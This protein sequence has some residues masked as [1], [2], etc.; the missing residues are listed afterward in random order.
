DATQIGQ[1][2]KADAIIVGRVTQFETLYAGLYASFSVAFELKMIASK[3]SEVLWSVK[4]TETQRTG[5]V[6]LSPIG[7]IIAAASTAM[8][9]SRYN[10]INTSNKLCQAS[11]E[12]I[13]PSSSLK[14]DS[15]PRIF[16]LVHDGV[17]RTLKKGDRLK[18][19]IEGSPGLTASFVISPRK[20]PITMQEE[21]GGSYIGTYIVRG[22]DE[23]S[24]GQ[25]VVTLSDDWN[26]ICRWEDTLGLVQLDGIPP[27]AITGI[28]AI[29]NDGQ[30][31]LKWNGS[32][33]KDI[34]GY[35]VLRSLTPLSGYKEITYTEFTRFTDKKLQNDTTY[36]YRIA[37][38]DKAGNLSQMMAGTPVTPVPPGP[39][40]VNG[41]LGSETVWHPGGNPYFLDEE[42]LL[43]TDSR[44][45]I[46]PGV[47]IKSADTSRFLVMGQLT[48][49]GEAN[50]PVIFSNDHEGGIW[51]GVVFEHADPN[52]SMT[53]FEISGALVGI[54]I[55]DASPKITSGTIKEC[56]T[57]LIITGE[58]AAPQI[59]TITVYRNK[60]NG[61]IVSD[62][63]NPR[64]TTSKI[65]YNGAAGVEL[66]RA[67]GKILGNEIS[68]N[69]LGVHMIQ[70]P[71]VFAGNRIQFNTDVDLQSEA[72]PLSALKIDLNYF[73]DIQAITAV[74]SSSDQVGNNIMVLESSDVRGSRRPL[75]FEAVKDAKSANS[76][77]FLQISGNKSDRTLLAKD[78]QAAASN[79]QRKDDNDG[80][81]KSN[82]QEDEQ[83]S[84]N[85][86]NAFIQG[87]TLAQKEAYTDAISF[88]EQALEDDSR[89][90]EVRFW[91]GFCY[92]QLGEIKKALF[93]YHK[94][95]KLHPEN[96][97]YLLHL[98]TALHLDDRPEKAKIV[99]QEV[100]RRD[101]K[102]KDAMAFLQLLEENQ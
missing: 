7:A 24:D 17:N 16:T 58:K 35:Q 4:H 101:P 63:A 9:L 82:S 11:I 25:V 28:K 67:N 88:F 54:R 85:P 77:Q 72:L 83:L 42:V 91:M 76:E 1:Q 32:S 22:E 96:L 95:V 64:I 87:T 29:A 6:P 89:E 5:K 90:A 80:G 2:L 53:H 66:S 79:D 59:E 94:A 61:I 47:I 102:N 43:P 27:E 78:T 3:D 30:V 38:K 92:V 10:M 84:K 70:A 52:S 93:H 36:F 97:D 26:N 73:G 56:Q 51:E 50:A 65:A 60:K 34:A 21:E 49:N 81:K 15:Y 98:G 20:T 45:R 40:V 48:V 46:E 57:G 8:D 23:L 37:A 12:T 44:L 100:L 69:K 99:Y 14:G 31:D 33:A 62:L 41:E 18:V 86:L 13:P 19:G 71:S 74:S 55:S 68:Y 39:T 75:T